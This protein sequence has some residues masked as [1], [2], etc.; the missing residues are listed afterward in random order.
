[1]PQ[2]N[3]VRVPAYGTQKGDL[4]ECQKGPESGQGRYK[5]TARPQISKSK[6]L[7]CYL[8]IYEY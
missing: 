5:Q 7:P 8:A 1:M 3:A 2:I 4:G 6:I